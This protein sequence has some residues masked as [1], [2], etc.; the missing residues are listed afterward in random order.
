MRTWKWFP[1]FPKRI[2]AVLALMAIMV[3]IASTAC[4]PENVSQ[5]VPTPVP[6][7]TDLR[8]IAPSRPREPSATPSAASG[9]SISPDADAVIPS[10]SGT[11][12]PSPS[13]SAPPAAVTI[14]LTAQN[15]SF[16]K[17]MITVPAWASVT[18]NFNNNDPGIYDNFSL[19][20]DQTTTVSIFIGDSIIGPD[21]TTYS[22]SA[23]GKQESISSVPTIIRLV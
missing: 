16:D 11:P 15:L 7:L 23:P 3:S 5:T 6:P 13:P 12:A 8:S 4:V 19:Y 22:F 2:I 9:P 21:K 17:N 10:P 14:D 20:S 1:C 18:L